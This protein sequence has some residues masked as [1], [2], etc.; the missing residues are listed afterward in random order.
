MISTRNH[1]RS[2]HRQSSPQ[3][4]VDDFKS[5]PKRDAKK[6]ENMKNMVDMTPFHHMNH[7]YIYN[8]VYVIYHILYTSTINYNINLYIY[9]IV[10]NI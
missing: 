6:E 8:T 2:R 9:S 1:P 5:I 4:G 10:H 7:I 3:W